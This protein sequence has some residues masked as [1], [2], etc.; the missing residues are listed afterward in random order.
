MDLEA[1]L[2]TPNGCEEQLQRLFRPSDRLVI[3]DVGACEGED[4]IRYSRLYPDAHVFA[5]EPLSANQAL[6]RRNF[7]THSSGRCELVPCALSDQTG[8]AVLHVSSGAPEEKFFGEH[9]NYGNKSSSLLPPRAVGATWLPWLQFKQTET[10][11]TDTL[12]RFCA[13]RGIERVDFIHM[14]VQGAE[15]LVLQGAQA[16]LPRIRAL[17]M[18][19]A[20]SEL[21]RG[22]KLG[23]EIQS[24]MHSRGFAVMH[25]DMRGMEGDQL[26]VNLRFGR[27]VAGWAQGAARRAF[28]RLARGVRRRANRL[29]GR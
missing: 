7:A 23:R 11:Q 18:E 24:F 6:V 14:D 1:Y 13:H 15:W 19:V 9:W 26:Y 21:Y 2:A 5:F 12:D 3:F 29:L 22:Q 4:S 28:G 16:M 8:T 17:W 10:I 25:E 20:S 27:N